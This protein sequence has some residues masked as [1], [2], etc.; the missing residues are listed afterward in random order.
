M[1]YQEYLNL[2]IDDIHRY[3]EVIGYKIKNDIPLSDEEEDVYHHMK[4][5]IQQIRLESCFNLKS[6]EKE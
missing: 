2:S 5:Y 4:R 3:K 1:D 6:Y